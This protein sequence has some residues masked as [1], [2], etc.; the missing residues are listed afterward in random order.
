MRPA[1]RPLAFAWDASGEARRVPAEESAPGSAPD[2]AGAFAYEV[3]EAVVGREN[4][5]R[6][7]TRVRSNNGSPGVDGMTVAELS[8]YLK[9]AW[10]RLKRELLGGTCQPQPVKRVEIPK[11]GGV[12]RALGIP[13]VVDRFIQR[14]ILHVLTP[15]Y[16]PTFS[17]SSYG[18][19]PGRSAHQALAD[20]VAI[21]RH[22]GTPQGGPASPFRSVASIGVARAQTGTLAC[23]AQATRIPQP[24]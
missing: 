4:L 21:D 7:L 10:P 1:V 3:M 15:M 2:R 20:G 14:A 16:Q 18:F 8:G 5:P 19:R 23:E 17:A 24:P 13:T 22:E 12:V 6:A 9:A 11:P